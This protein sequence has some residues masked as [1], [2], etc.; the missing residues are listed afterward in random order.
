MATS[1]VAR[2]AKLI[3]FV[4]EN[5]DATSV[6]AQD[7]SGA[8]GDL[9]IMMVEVDNTNNTSTAV[10]AALYNSGSDINVGVT[11]PDLLF[12]VQGRAKRQF[13]GLLATSL[14]ATTTFAN[15]AVAAVTDA[16]AISG[17]PT[18]PTS[19]VTVRVGI[20]DVS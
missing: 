15:L 16:G 8:V 1:F 3:D 5:T 12:R 20:K 14:P 4:A 18:S 10:H 2:R 13:I 17:S 7:M 11:D 19:D 6:E 9:G